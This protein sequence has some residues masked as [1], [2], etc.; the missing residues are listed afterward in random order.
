MCRLAL[1]TSERSRP[2]LGLAGAR[3]DLAVSV[4]EA[5]G[6]NEPVAKWKVAHL[7]AARWWF[8]GALIS[9]VATA[10]ILVLYV[11][12]GPTNVASEQRGPAHRPSHHE[13]P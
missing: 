11:G 7:G 9:L 2:G 8:L 6:A 12:L 1:S 3:V 4:L 5:A 10:T 13:S